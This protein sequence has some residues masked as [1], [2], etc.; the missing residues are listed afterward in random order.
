M[1]KYTRQH[2]QQIANL[3]NKEYR[4]IKNSD[5]E[6]NTQTRQIDVLRSVAFNFDIMFGLD[7]ERFN[8]DLFYKATGIKEMIK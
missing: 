2:Y 7:N 5:T 1:A 3:L 8:K 4:M 6:L